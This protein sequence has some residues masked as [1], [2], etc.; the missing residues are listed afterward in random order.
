MPERRNRIKVALPLYGV[1]SATFLQHWLA[2]QGQ[3]AAYDKYSGLTTTQRPYV[4]FAMNEIVA[5]ALQMSAWDYLLII[6][7]DMVMPPGILERIATLDPETHPI[8]GC[9]YFGRVQE[10]QRPVTGF[11][12]ENILN[13]LSYEEV[14]KMLPER[15]GVAGFHK[16]DVVG[17][18]A[19]AIHRSVLEK[20]PWTQSHP[21]FRTEYDDLGFLGHDI[22]FCTEAAK[23]GYPVYVDS[24]M[25]AEHIG[26]WR[27]N[28]TTYLATAEHSMVEEG[29][30]TGWA[31][32]PTMM[33]DHELT[34]LGQIAEGKRVLEVGSQYGNSTVAMARTA[35]QVVAIDW[36]A[37]DGHAGAAGAEL[38]RQVYFAHLLQMGVADKVI[39][40]ASRWEDALPNLKGRFDL[41]FIDAFHSE[42]ATRELLH[43]V[44]PLLA[45]DGL[46]AAHDYGRFGVKPA[47]DEFQG[48]RDLTV[49]DT[50]A[51]VGLDIP[52]P[53][54]RSRIV[55]P[56][57]LGGLRSETTEALTNYPADFELMEAEDSYF[58][59]I[60]RLWAAGRT[61]LTV[62]QD[63][64][65]TE[66]QLDELMSCGELWCAYE[67]EYPP[68]GLYAG[69]GCTKFSAQL[70]HAAHR[71][72]DITGTWKDAKH[73]PMHWCRVDGW[74]KKYL[75]DHGFN[76]HVHGEVKHLHKGRPAHNCTGP[77]EAARIL[78]ASRA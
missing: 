7:Q 6:E 53:D 14:C 24:S 73:P 55:V 45:P 37:G 67:Y 57:V 61:F 16:V 35:K 60:R 44:E 15:G 10:D 56:F 41:I 39:T 65:P 23:L 17:M 28:K 33:T 1:V 64:V 4:D 58:Q 66:Q 71:A 51:V 13:R 2:F 69:M 72:L 50:L 29:V 18:G 70:L 30:A 76:Q 75:L 32:P 3:I 36:F 19:T 42:E 54:L 77:Q 8:V 21:F 48:D 34:Y 26:E 31:P 63:I 74:L 52:V 43:A 49:V 68:F 46:I 12:R 78:T 40:M 47:I 22:W 38:T 25:I 11:M 9:L 20:W 62:E 27:S 59:L 5:G